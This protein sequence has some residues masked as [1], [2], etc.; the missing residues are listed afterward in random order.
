LNKPTKRKDSNLE[1]TYDWP[2]TSVDDKT[3]FYLVIEQVSPWR[4]WFRAI[5]DGTTTQL[6]VTQYGGNT[7][8]PGS[9]QVIAYKAL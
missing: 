4:V 6:K 7:A 8:L 5:E 9:I 1:S 2:S 3:S